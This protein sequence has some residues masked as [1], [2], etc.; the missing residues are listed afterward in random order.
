[1]CMY[2]SVFLVKKVKHS[3][4]S[5]MILLS[6]VLNSDNKPLGNSFFLVYC[7]NYYA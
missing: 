2:F 3:D 6:T 4:A 5:L 1:M 7:N